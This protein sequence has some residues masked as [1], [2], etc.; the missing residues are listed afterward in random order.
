[1]ALAAALC[2]GALIL[3]AS[4]SEILWPQNDKTYYVPPDV[5]KFP[6]FQQAFA[7]ELANAEISE[8][9]FLVRLDAL[10]EEMIDKVIERGSLNRSDNFAQAE[11]TF[12]KSTGTITKVTVSGGAFLDMPERIDRVLV[13][14]VAPGAIDGL[15]TVTGIALPETLEKV[16]GVIIRNCPKLKHISIPLAAVVTGKI[17]ENC[18]HMEGADGSGSDFK[19]VETD[20]ETWLNGDGTVGRKSLP[21][22]LLTELEVFRGNGSDMNWDG[23]LTRVE[24]ATLLLRLQGLEE[25]AQ[26]KAGQASPF[27]DVPQWANGYVNLAYERGMV[28]GVG[29]GRFDPSGKCGVQEFSL[30]LLRLTD[31]AEGTDYGWGTA[32]QDLRELIC[33]SRALAGYDSPEQVDSHLYT[34]LA[35]GAAFT[36]Q[37]ACALM[38]RALSIPAGGA[39]DCSLGDKLASSGALPAMS[40]LERQ[41]RLTLAAAMKESG[42]LELYCG[43]PA[44]PNILTFQDGTATIT[45]PGNPSLSLSPLEGAYGGRTGQTSLKVTEP[46]RLHIYTDLGDLT[47]TVQKDSEG[48]LCLDTLNGRGD[49]E[50]MIYNRHGLPEDLERAYE[51]EPTA[52]SQAVVDLARELTAGLTD[53][54]DKARVI[55]LWIQENIRYD[56]ATLAVRRGMTQDETEELTGHELVGGLDASDQD[57]DTVLSRRMGVCAGYANLTEAMLDAVGIPVVYVANSMRNHA[58]N[59]ARINGRDVYIDNTW[60]EFDT[61]RDSFAGIH[62]MDRSQDTFFR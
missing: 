52:P 34:N 30:M 19:Y 13:E 36:R 31:Y 35:N 62:Q 37:Y 57:A 44:V 40:L 28:K 6:P 56:Y 50:Q 42:V 3:P 38:Y 41:V 32:V 55:S 14:A 16:E 27:T 26:A 33:Q 23:T 10:V 2:A 12:D 20:V 53:D 43:A 15:D 1:M 61:P 9:E 49:M 21:E 60:E 58:W 39:G 18:P 5:Y 54:Y 45:G 46:A 29:D 17:Y 47:L 24:A 48:R 22:A 7:E 59:V 25:E 11:Y 51:K 4:A 8:A